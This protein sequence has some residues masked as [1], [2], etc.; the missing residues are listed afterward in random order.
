MTVVYFHSVLALPSGVDLL[1]S[2]VKPSA[3]TRYYIDAKE[4]NIPGVGFITM[5]T[6]L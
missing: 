6:N 2:E 1:I 5:T 4:K 3:E